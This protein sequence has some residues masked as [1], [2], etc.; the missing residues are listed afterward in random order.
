MLIT[1]TSNDI[2]L[3]LECN[4]MVYMLYFVTHTPTVTKCPNG[5]ECVADYK[6]TCPTT[7][8]FSVTESNWIRKNLK[9]LRITTK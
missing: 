3:F 4:V 7:V 8:V 5:H 1:H 2:Q 6:D 9:V